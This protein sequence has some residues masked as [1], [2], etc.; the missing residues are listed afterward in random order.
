MDRF[1]ASATRSPSS[2]PRKK[3]NGIEDAQIESTPATTEWVKHG[4]SAALTAMGEAVEE[5][6][7]KT[8]RVV[9][10]H[11]SEISTLRQ[12]IADVRQKVIGVEQGSAQRSNFKNEM[13]ELRNKM[14]Q[15]AVQG[16]LDTDDATTAVCGN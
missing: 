15:T 4:I 13:E 6:I 3:A 5:R 8:E 10:G 1:F 2:P 11:T 7:S 14:E 12:E 9:E 16:T